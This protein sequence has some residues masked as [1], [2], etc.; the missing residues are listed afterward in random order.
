MVPKMLINSYDVTKTDKYAPS[1]TTT[2]TPMII[3]KRWTT[4]KEVMQYGNMQS[5]VCMSEEVYISYDV[6][7][8]YKK[9]K[10]A[11]TIKQEIDH[12]VKISLAV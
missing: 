12:I 4:Y 9:N 1:K 6:S 11:Y 7:R 8:S 10:A 3:D 5:Q 2:K